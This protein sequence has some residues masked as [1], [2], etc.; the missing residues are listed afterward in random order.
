MTL[1]SV[2]RIEG[3]N[4]EKR[5]NGESPSDVVRAN[6]WWVSSEHEHSRKD[7]FNKGPMT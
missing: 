1:C 7:H 2:I 3:E 4:S 6:R 5:Q